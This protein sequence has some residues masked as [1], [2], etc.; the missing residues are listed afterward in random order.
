MTVLVTFIF[1]SGY[2]TD[3]RI[4]YEVLLALFTST[5]QVRRRQVNSE[6]R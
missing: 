6:L 4:L 5:S 2:D 3:C 1:A